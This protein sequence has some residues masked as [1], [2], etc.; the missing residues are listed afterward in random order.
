MQGDLLALVTGGREN[1]GSYKQKNVLRKDVVQRFVDNK[2][3]CT[4]ETY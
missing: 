3:V 1:V 2:R 4:K